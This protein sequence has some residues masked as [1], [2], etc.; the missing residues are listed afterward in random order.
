[1]RVLIVEDEVLV[2]AEIE[3]LIAEAGLQT[4][5]VAISSEEALK[6]VEQ[7]RPDLVL[8]DVHLADGP[9]GIEIARRAAK[10]QGVAV[11]FMT[12]NRRRLPDD[13]AGAIGSVAKPYT[14]WGMRGALR[15]I[16][17]CLRDGGATRPAPSSLELSSA[18]S[19]KWLVPEVGHSTH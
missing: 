6:I 16:A 5:G 3:F 8:L 1:M 19:R 2:A 7:E 15:F 4:L 12:A 17:E 18:W 11:L 10:L 13:F 14:E 9:T